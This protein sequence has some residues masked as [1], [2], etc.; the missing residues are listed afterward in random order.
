MF[1]MFV[2]A[3]T[4][5]FLCILYKHR[6]ANG[7]PGAVHNVDSQEVKES[8]TDASTDASTELQG[9]SNEKAKQNSTDLEDI[10]D[11]DITSM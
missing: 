3:N 1:I 2:S 4:P 9:S 10:E 7:G 6:I 8:E 5:A 11:H